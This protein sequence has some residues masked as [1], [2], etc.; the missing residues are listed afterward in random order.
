MPEDL[1]VNQQAATVNDALRYLP[2][3]EVR[4]QQGYEVSRPQSRGFQ[5][6]I[7]QNTRLDGLNIDRHDGDPDGESLQHSGAERDWPARSTG[8]TPRPACS[9][10][11]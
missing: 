5:G 3:V 11:S 2:S 10:T 8:P 9:T 4:D 7:V 1:L 6:G